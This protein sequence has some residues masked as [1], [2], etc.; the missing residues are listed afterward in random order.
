MKLKKSQGN[1][2][3]KVPLTLP[4]QFGGAARRFG[5]KNKKNWVDFFW[6]FWGLVFGFFKECFFVLARR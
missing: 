6:A 3:L 2:R 1:L 5:R 4:A